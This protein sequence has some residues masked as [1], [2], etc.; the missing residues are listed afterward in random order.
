MS[1]I[2]VIGFVIFHCIYSN[3]RNVCSLCYF[4]YWSFI[5]IVLSAPTY[6]RNKDAKVIYTQYKDDHSNNVKGRCLLIEHRPFPY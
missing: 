6:I 1:I 5:F 3:C 4:S 2:P